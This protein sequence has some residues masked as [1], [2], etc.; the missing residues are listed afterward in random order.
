MSNS[1]TIN[2]Q[3]EREAKVNTMD[4]MCGMNKGKQTYLNLTR[5]QCIDRFLD[6]NPTADARGG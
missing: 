1:D 6:W 5:R 4:S 3:Q 2:Q